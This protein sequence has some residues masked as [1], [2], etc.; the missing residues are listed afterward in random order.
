MGEADNLGPAYDFNISF[1]PK[2]LLPG[3]SGLFVDRW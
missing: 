2:R 1:A 3:L